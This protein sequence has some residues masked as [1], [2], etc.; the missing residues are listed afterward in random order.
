[1]KKINTLDKKKRKAPPAA[2]FNRRYSRLIRSLKQK[3]TKVVLSMG[4]GGIRM[5]AHLSVL[6][7]LE[8]LGIDKHVSEVWGSSGGAIVGMFF[9]MGLNADDIMKEAEAFFKDHH[10]QLYPSLF[11]MA[12]NMIRE[13]FLAD[14]SPTVLKGFHDI[15]ESLRNLVSKTLATGKERFPWYC[16]AYNLD[17]NRTDVL[18]PSAIPEGVYSDFIYQTDALDAIVA[19]SSI[20]VL[21]VPKVIADADGKRTYADGATGEEIP[22]VSLYKKWVQDREFGLEKRKRLLVIAVDLGTDLSTVG[23]F[24][25]WL[26]RKIPAF[27][28][29]R[30]TVHLTDL[31]RRARIAEQ[32][33]ML[34]HD[35][36]VEL[37]EVNLNLS[38][39]G[40]LDVNAI[41]A[42]LRLADEGV[43]VEFAKLNDELLT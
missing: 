26:L 2:P 15:Q 18:T 34:M 17:K 42:V 38:K 6:R 36:N 10:L 28:F 27:Q 16:L 33:R 31:M 40:F 32:K 3:D 11:S 37:W 9:S 41:P 7:F 23:F 21:F 12:K 25:R 29:L 14:N 43:P 30:M 5:F 24:E 13:A 20:P 22:T 4:S 19:T 39:V 1:M 35:P 8:K